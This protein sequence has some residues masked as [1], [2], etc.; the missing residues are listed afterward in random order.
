MQKIP[1]TDA[2]LKDIIN[3]LAY[4]V[5]SLSHKLHRSSDQKTYETMVETRNRLA[6]LNFRLREFRREANGK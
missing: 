3:T 5:H 4:R 6:Q 1:I 2:D